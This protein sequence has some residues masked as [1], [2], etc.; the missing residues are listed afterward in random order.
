MIKKSN[1]YFLFLLFLFITYLCY[2]QN[3]GAYLIPRQ[4]YVGDPAALVLPLPPAE[5]NNA[6]IVIAS[7]SDYLPS[8]PNIDFHRIILERRT[9][10]S[11]LMIEFAP[12]IPGFIE[13][14]VIEIGGEYFS[15]LTVTVNSMID[16]RSTPVLSGAAAPLAMPG[17]ALMLYGSL[18]AVVFILLFAFF[19]FIKGR[20]LLKELT[21]KWKIYKLFSAL[22]KIEK[23]LYKEITAGGDKRV[24]LDKLSDEF[25]EFL[26]CLTGDNCRAMTADEFNYL[27]AEFLIQKES[28]S[29]LSAF[30]RSCDD[31]RFSGADINSDFIISLLNDM[32]QFLVILENAFKKKQEEGT[33]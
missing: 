32:K 2:A 4:I 3:S 33:S 12:F 21:E 9:T 28:A 5:Q 8:D 31:L 17:T 27:E 19:F 24:I 10:G 20:Y 11:R 13:L 22:R 18:T 25:R 23:S 7:P 16:S 6:D 14:P 26:S 29:F 30:F 1:K 15:G